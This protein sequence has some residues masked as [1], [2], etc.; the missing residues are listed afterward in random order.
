MSD[1]WAC[2]LLAGIC[3]GLGWWVRGMWREA[4]T[5]DPKE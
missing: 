1:P 2:A 4:G 3:F 5:G